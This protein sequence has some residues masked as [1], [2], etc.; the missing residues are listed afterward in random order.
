MAKPRLV[1]LDHDDHSVTDIINDLKVRRPTTAP[2]DALSTIFDFVP[3]VVSAEG[4]PDDIARAAKIE[5]HKAR[6]D[7]ILVD[8]NFTDDTDA[9]T[10]RRGADLAS[11]L[12]KWFPAVPIGVYSQFALERVDRIA[13]SEYR[14]HVVLEDLHQHKVKRDEFTNSDW[15][16]LLKRLTNDSMPVFP[17]VFLSHAHADAAFATAVKNLLQAALDLN[18]A[19]IVVSSAGG[20]GFSP[21]A[22]VKRQAVAGVGNADCVIVLLTPNSVASNYVWFEYGLATATKPGAIIPLTTAAGLAQKSQ[23]PLGDDVIFRSDQR[24][25]LLKLVTAV[26]Q[27]TGAEQQPSEEWDAVL[28]SVLEM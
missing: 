24:N 16:D 21:G 9:T 4:G 18:K 22:S 3:V 7:A 2:T 17:R 28:Q 23:T 14:F 12:R 5:I 10:W 19:D 1:F 15:R 27:A 13:L 6:P 26:R 11:A 8:L 25:D 20:S